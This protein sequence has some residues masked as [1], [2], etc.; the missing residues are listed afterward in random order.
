MV[1]KVIGNGWYLIVG[2]KWL[3]I[4]EGKNSEKLSLSWCIKNDWKFGRDC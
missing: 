4:V 1:L 2:K 3:K